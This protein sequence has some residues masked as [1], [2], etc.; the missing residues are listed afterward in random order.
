MW[1]GKSWAWAQNTPFREFKSHVHEG[2][3]ATPMIAHWPAGIDASLQGGWNQD[4][5]HVIDLM[6]T[7][8]DLA[9]AKYPAKHN[10]LAI[11]PILTHRFAYRE[12]QQGFDIMRS[13]QSGKVVLDW[14]G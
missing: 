12:F 9:G 6:S 13:G 2:G 3:I 10:G 7:C 4:V 5:G 8:V 14:T 11:T 1:C